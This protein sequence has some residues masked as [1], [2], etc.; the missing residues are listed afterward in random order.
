MSLSFAVEDA[1]ITDASSFM[2]PLGGGRSETR[3]PINCQETKAARH[4]NQI[5]M[6]D[7]ASGDMT[8]SSQNGPQRSR[9]RDCGE[10]SSSSNANEG[11]GDPTSCD[12]RLNSQERTSF[13]TTHED[14]QRQ[15][16][17]MNELDTDS[18]VSPVIPIQNVRTFYFVA[19]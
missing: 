8:Q 1:S 17:R 14:G 9:S 18:L 19:K 5:R 11:V 6:N 12:N 13:P 16:T 10:T 4:D 3:N 7:N 2:Q 15:S